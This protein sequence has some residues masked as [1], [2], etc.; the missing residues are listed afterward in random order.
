MLTSDSAS[1]L[2]VVIPQSLYPMTDGGNFPTSI[3]PPNAVMS[4]NSNPPNGLRLPPSHVPSFITMPPMVSHLIQPSPVMPANSF[5]PHGSLPPNTHPIPN[6]LIQIN[7]VPS[8]GLLPPSSYPVPSS[9]SPCNSFLPQVSLPLQYPYPL[10]NS[11]IQ[12]NSVPPLG[13]LPLPNLHPRPSSSSQGNPI[14]P[15]GSLP[16][17]DSLSLPSS[18]VQ[19]KSFPLLGSLLPQNSYSVLN[20]LIQNDLCPPLDS[21]TQRC[22]PMPSTTKSVSIQSLIPPLSSHHPTGEM[23]QMN[24]RPSNTFVPP[25]NS[26]TTSSLN[27]DEP[28]NAT[29]FST[30]HQDNS[31]SNLPSLDTIASASNRKVPRAIFGRI[32]RDGESKA[33]QVG[34][35]FNALV[36]CQV[37]CNTNWLFY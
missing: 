23:P 13:L 34:Y 11:M 1:L 36:V 7:S 33:N 16:I 37:S 35:V 21:S 3:P 4:F 10:P 22:H 19:I 15:L 26:N 31:C 2:D 18:S 32:A 14:P 25:S 29:V 24:W 12:I 27:K 20:P 30:R 6:S 17:P 28:P 5:P 8:L 9:A